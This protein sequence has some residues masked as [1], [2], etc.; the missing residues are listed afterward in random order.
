MKRVS[1]KQSICPAVI[2]NKNLKSL[3]IALNSIYAGYNVIVSHNG[4]S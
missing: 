3:R 1:D 2:C 4:E